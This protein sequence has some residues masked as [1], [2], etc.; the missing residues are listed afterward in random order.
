MLQ[1]RGVPQHIER[2][3]CCIRATERSAANGVID[4]TVQLI[5]FATSTA[6]G[7]AGAAAD[8]RDGVEV[9]CDAAREGV[10]G[11]AVIGVAQQREDIIAYLADLILL[12]TGNWDDR[13]RLRLED[14][15]SVGDA[16]ER[17]AMLEAFASA[18]VGRAGKT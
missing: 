1:Q 6:D 5:R 9:G 11:V 10:S 15:R 3:A 12:D 2:C 14:A 16:L 4:E 18:R 13:R 7:A 17:R 8:N